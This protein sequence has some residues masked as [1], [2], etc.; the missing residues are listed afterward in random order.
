MFSIKHPLGIKEGKGI[1]TEWHSF[2]CKTLKEL[3]VK[4]EVMQQ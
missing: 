2:P 1:L 4:S 3:H